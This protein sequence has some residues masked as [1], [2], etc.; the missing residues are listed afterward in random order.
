MVIHSVRTSGTARFSV[1]ISLTFVKV[2]VIVHYMRDHPYLALPPAAGEALL[3]YLLPNE[4]RSLSM[5]GHAQ[6]LL[7]KDDLA[8][9]HGLDYDFGDRTIYWAEMGEVCCFLPLG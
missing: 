4:I 3:V 7:A 5:R 1:R 8:D 2:V 9:M 6:H